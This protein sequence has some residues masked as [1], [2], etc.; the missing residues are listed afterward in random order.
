MRTELNSARAFLEAERLSSARLREELVKAKEQ[1]AA[2]GKR[3]SVQSAPPPMALPM[4]VRVQPTAI[5]P[6]QRGTAI[7]V[8]SLR[9]SCRAGC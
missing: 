3:V 5:M 2:M 1:L 7:G 4:P 6:G 9:S 8:G